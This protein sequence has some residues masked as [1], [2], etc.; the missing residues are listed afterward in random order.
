MRVIS[1]RQTFCRVQVGGNF[2]GGDLFDDFRWGNEVK[3][4]YGGKFR[5]FHFLLCL[6]EKLTRLFM[7]RFAQSGKAEFSGP[8]QVALSGEAFQEKN[9]KS[10]ENSFEAVAT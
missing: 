1:G 4:D 2:P 5:L 8:Q 7:K 3:I 6:V 9:R 10:S